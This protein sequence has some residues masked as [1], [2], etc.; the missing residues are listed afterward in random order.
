[1]WCAARAF[2][3]CV[4]ARW[5]RG[6]TRAEEIDRYVEYVSETGVRALSAT[7]GNLGV[8]VLTR[9]EGVRAE[10]V[11][12]SLWESLDRVRAFAGPDVERAVFFPE[13]EA[14][15]VDRDWSV[16]HYQVPVALQAP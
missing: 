12:I 4:I 5:W 14:F 16:V 3:G 10:M 8:Y 15:L 1:M 7:P 2:S 11:V 9:I 6:W 13:D